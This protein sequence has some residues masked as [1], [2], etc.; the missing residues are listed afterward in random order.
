MDSPSIDTSVTTETLGKINSHNEWDRLRE[1]IVGTA[2]NSMAVL[3]WSRPDPIPEDV[4]E[5]AYALAKQAFPRWFVDEVEEDLQ[6]L[7][8]ILKGFGVKVHRPRPFENSRMYSSPFW[9]ST[10]NNVYNV[11]DLNLVVGNTVIESPSDQRCR[12]F[13]TVALYHIWHEYFKKGS[14]WVAAPKPRLDYE[15]LTPYYR[16]DQARVLSEEEILYKKLTNGLVEKLHRLGENEILFEA[17]NTLRMGKDLLYLVSSSGN[18]L[19]AQWLQNVLGDAYRVHTTD[20]IYRSSHIDSTALC[21]RPGL[22]LLNSTRVNER[23]C[24]EI[25][26]KWDKIYFQD[27]APMAD[28]EIEFQKTVREPLGN[29]LKEMGFITNLHEIASPWVGMNVLSIDPNTVLIDSRQ[30]E[31]IKV[32]ERHKFTVATVRIRH[33]YTQGGGIHCATLDTVRDSKLESYFD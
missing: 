29:Q 11:R 25:F 23:N 24:P 30:T 3:T 4:K 16:D 27:V 31:L 28:P 5:K 2:A 1:T 18:R 20:K 21:L 7:C 22:V 8:D 33:I 17:A 26:A 32:L 13:E 10:S 12:Y 14:H 6:G 19:G 15:V 9:S